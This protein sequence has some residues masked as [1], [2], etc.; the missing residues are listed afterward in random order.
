MEN[1][2][3]K[4]VIQ[5]TSVDRDMNKYPDVFIEE[6]EQ[7]LALIWNDYDALEEVRQRVVSL[8]WDIKDRQGELRYGHLKKYEPIVEGPLKI[9]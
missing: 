4:T 7:A 9:F 3:G 1:L 6:I 2:T 5:I 8:N